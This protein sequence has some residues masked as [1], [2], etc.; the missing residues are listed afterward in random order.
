MGNTFYSEDYIRANYQ[1]VD[2]EMAQVSVREVDNSDNKTTSVT[3]FDGRMLV[4]DFPDK[5]VSS[6]LIYSNKFKNRALRKKDL[7][8]EKVELEGTQFNK[9][10]DVY[11]PVP[12]DV[13][14][15]LTPQL[16]ERLQ[17]LAGKYES[18]AMDVV[19]N[20]VILAFNEPGKNAFDQDMDIGKLDYDKEVNKV[21]AEID[22][23]KIFISM[24]LNLEIK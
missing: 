14:Y 11:S 6:V 1:G 17:F 2:F 16:M 20:R 23:I 21:Q 7:K 5:I 13:F 4:F 18:I 8:K 22:D 19:G 12:H 15:L 9:D 24:I 3:Y 10:F